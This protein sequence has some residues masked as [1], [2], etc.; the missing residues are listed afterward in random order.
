MKKL[1]IINILLIV[2]FILPVFIS[3]CKDTSTAPNPVNINYPTSNISYSQYIQP[4][5]NYHCTAKGC[6][7]DIDMG[8]GFSLTSYLEA[9]SKVS[10]GHPEVSPLV[11]VAK[12]DPNHPVFNSVPLNQKEIAAVTTWVK[13]GAKNN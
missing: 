8:G 11:L 3:S 2:L 13:E 6:H 4:I 10:P 5:L 12:G 9:W 1:C 7:N